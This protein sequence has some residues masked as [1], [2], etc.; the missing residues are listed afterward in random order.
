MILDIYTDAAS[1]TVRKIRTGS[2]LV[3]QDDPNYTAFKYSR[4][5]NINLLLQEMHLEKN[6]IKASISIAELYSIMDIIKQV[7]NYTKDNNIKISEI[8]IYTD[9]MCSFNICNGLQKN[10]KCKLTNTISIEINNYFKKLKNQNIIKYG[11][12]TKFNIMWIKGHVGVFGNELADSLCKQ[13]SPKVNE[14]SNFFHQQS[15]SQH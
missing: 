1:G 10:I 15:Y 3:N 14:I 12:E 9:S 4:K 13:T 2:I 7:Y 5:F 8:N 11:L 6:T